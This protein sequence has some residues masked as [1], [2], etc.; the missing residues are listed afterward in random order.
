V[1]IGE[2]AAGAPLATAGYYSV[3]A[4]VLKDADQARREG[5]GALRLFLERLLNRGYRLG[6]VE[7]AAG[8]DVDRPGDI[9]SAEALL[10]QVGA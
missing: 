8:V 2:A 7:V 4:T 1:A 9:R 3:R 10:R 5:L 6:A